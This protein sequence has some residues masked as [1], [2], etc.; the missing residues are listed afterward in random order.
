MLLM[1]P[2]GPPLAFPNLMRTLADALFVLH[3]F[4][5]GAAGTGNAGKPDSSSAPV[6]VIA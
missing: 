4:L 1:T 2:F 6:A 5:L 3:G